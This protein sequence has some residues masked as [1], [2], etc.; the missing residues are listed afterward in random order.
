MSQVSRPVRAE[1]GD[2]VGG[3]LGCEPMGLVLAG[4]G[5]DASAQGNGPS[6]STAEKVSKTATEAVIAGHFK[7]FDQLFATFGAGCKNRASILNTPSI[8]SQEPRS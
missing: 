7:H 1:A 5:F 4:R 6:Q 3:G 8:T 2:G